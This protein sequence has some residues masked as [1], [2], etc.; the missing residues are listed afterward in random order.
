M[1]REKWNGR[2]TGQN[3][4]KRGL[5]ARLKR[6]VEIEITISNQSTALKPYRFT[7]DGENSQ[8]HHHIVGFPAVGVGYSSLDKYGIHTPELYQT[9]VERR[10]DAETGVKSVQWFNFN[11]MW[12]VVDSGAVPED[13]LALEPKGSSVAAARKTRSEST[14]LFLF[15]Y[16]DGLTSAVFMLPD[17]INFCR[18]AVKVKGQA[19]PLATLAEERWRPML[20]HFANQLKALEKMFHTGKPSYP[21]ERTL[22]TTGILERALASR[23]EGGK[24]LITPELAIRYT[25]VTYPHAPRPPLTEPIG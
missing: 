8:P 1:T 24:K 25:P 7:P 12:K 16:N 23:F 3:L 19:K 13:V 21:V 5:L 6:V 22:L 20:P 10:R 11:D 4:E 14:G 15:E 17:P 9:L 18:V 2:T